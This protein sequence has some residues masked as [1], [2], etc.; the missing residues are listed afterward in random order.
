MAKDWT[1]IYKKYKGM[2]VALGQDEETVLSAS[3]TLKQAL[4]LAHRK[5]YKDPIMTRMPES[6]TT[7]VGV[8]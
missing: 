1:K 8:L 2:W 3:K 6:L 7:Y 4:E 5:G